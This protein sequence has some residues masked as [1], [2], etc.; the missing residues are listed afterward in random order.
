MKKRFVLFAFLI[1]I[2][3]NPTAAQE[4]DIG[5]FYGRF[6][7]LYKFT[8]NGAGFR[9]VPGSQ[10]NPYPTFGVNKKFSKKLSGEASLSFMAYVQYTG[11]RQHPP[12]IGFFSTYYGANI[13]ALAG[14]SFLELGEKFEARIKGGLGLG[15]VPDRYEGSFVEMLLNLETQTMDSISRGTINRDFVALFPTVCTGLDFSYRFSKQFKVSLLVNY[16]KGFSKITEYDI[17]Y[18]DGS[19]NN[20]QHARQWGTGDFYGFQLGLRYILKKKDKNKEGKN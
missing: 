10:Y 15:I 20:D 3:I 9:N 2:L 16:Q 5:L 11:T 7:A 14:Y 8:D 12:V 4:T 19:G 13:S 17:Y 18:N 1:G 6:Y